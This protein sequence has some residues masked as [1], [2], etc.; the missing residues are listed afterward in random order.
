M[1]QEQLDLLMSKGYDWPRHSVPHRN[2]QVG[3][4]FNSLTVVAIVRRVTGRISK[5]LCDCEC[6]NITLIQTSC[7]ANNMTKSCGCAHA[8]S[9]RRPTHGLSHLGIW[10]SWHNLIDR[11]TNPTHPS[12]ARYSVLGYPQEWLM[13]EVFYED[14]K[15][16]WFQ[17]ASIDRINNDEG[18]SVENAQW[19]T[20]SAHMSKTAKETRG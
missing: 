11:C 13:F 6:G 16:G 17:G 12:Y 3:D 14:M 2:M 4:T 10:K 9:G 1:T 7:L 8:N 19:L 18:Y 15:D 20:R 5:A